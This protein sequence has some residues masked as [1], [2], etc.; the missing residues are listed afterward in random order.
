[1]FDQ[2]LP[3]NE[4]AIRILNATDRLM[5]REGVQNLSTHKIAKEAGVSV[6][7][8]YLYFKD[9]DTLLHQLVLYL[10]NTFHSSV[11]QKYDPNLPLFEQY[12]A[13]WYATWQFMQNNPDVVKNMHQY[14]A[15]PQFQSTM[16][17]C[18]NIKELPWNIFV[19]QGQ[20][21]KMIINLPPT[22]LYAISMK[23]AW[24]LMYQQL[25]L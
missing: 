17:S 14:E 15:L 19:E 9:K 10:F 24:E 2:D 16:K 8:I 6:G 21:Q 11:V 5:A 12:Q 18:L 4:I 22:V 20:L 13:L 3:H 25:M 23:T 1:M 7:T